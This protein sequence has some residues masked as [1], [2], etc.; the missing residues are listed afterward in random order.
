[1]GDASRLRGRS[2]T[3][4]STKRLAFIAELAQLCR[5]LTVK[6]LKQEA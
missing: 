1:M 4:G 3:S 2:H 5:D 6:Q